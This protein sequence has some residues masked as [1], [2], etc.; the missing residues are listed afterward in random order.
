MPLENVFI[1]VAMLLLSAKVFGGIAER[2]GVS[3]LVGQI[4]GGIIIGPVL[5]LV[6]LS[7]FMEDFFIIPIIFLLFMTGMQI[8]FDEIKHHVYSAGV[9]AFLGGMFSFLLGTLVGLAFFNDLVIGFAIGVVLVSTS[10]VILFLFLME[11]G[12]FNTKLGK[13]I[14]SVTIADDVIGILFLSFFST[15]VKSHVV[16]FNGILF[17]FFVCIGFYLIM[18]TAGSKIANAILDFASRFLDENILFTIPIVFAFFLAYVTDNI[19]MSIAAGAFLAGMAIANSRY[20]ES[21]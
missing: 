20:A 11:T 16:A 5:G 19:G 14:V 1:V 18:F 9:L 15:F 17:L 13:F 12:Q 6:V 10:D 8:K 2:F 7:G 4:I 21:V 3:A